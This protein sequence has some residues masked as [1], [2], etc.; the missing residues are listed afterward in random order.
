M[1]KF[2]ILSSPIRSYWTPPE[3]EIPDAL[4]PEFETEEEKEEWL[5]EQEE[6]QESR[7]GFFK[8]F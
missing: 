8:G 6:E 7:E 5:K 4:I 1:I 3:A 2:G